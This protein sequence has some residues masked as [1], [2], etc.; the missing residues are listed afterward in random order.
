MTTSPLSPFPELP[1]HTP[2]Q[3]LP[4]CLATPTYGPGGSM[5]VACSTVLP[6]SPE[7]CLATMLQT[8]A[9]PLWNKFC[10][11]VTIQRSSAAVNFPPSVGKLLQGRNDVISAGSEVTFEVHMDLDEKVTVNQPIFVTHLEE[12][13]RGG[14]KGLRVAWRAGGAIPGLMLRSERVQEFIESEEGG[15]EYYCWETFYGMIVS[16]LRWSVGSKLQGGFA[17][18]MDGLGK[19]IDEVEA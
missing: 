19:S 12:F 6:K 14:K 10:P 11:R 18:W 17:A 8:S 3:I 16:V 7:R 15:C 1:L 5:T 13:E 2:A 4:S 9:W